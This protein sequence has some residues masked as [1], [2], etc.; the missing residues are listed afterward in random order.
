MNLHADYTTSYG[1][2]KIEKYI[3]IPMHSLGLLGNI[4]LWIVYSQGSLRKLSVSIYF[5]LVAIFCAFQCL[6]FLI[7]YIFD[8]SFS[9]IFKHSD[10]ACRLI[11]YSYFLPTPIA[12]WF[13]VAA[14][15]DRFL[16][17]VFPNKFTF[18]QRPIFQRI[19]VFAIIVYNMAF[20]FKNIFENNIENN[21]CVLD[22]NNPVIILDFINAGVCIFM[23][24]LI[25]TISTFYGVVQAH[26]R[27][28]LIINKDNLKRTRKRDI[29]F[30][31][32][33]I[34]LNVLFFI[35]NFP[36][37][38]NM[39]TFL[40]PFDQTAHPMAASVFITVLTYL[41]ELYFCVN[42]YIQLAVNNVVRKEFRNVLG[43]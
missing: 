33:M 23:L 36:Y 9:N 38:L 4:L 42:F 17:I 40:P 32:T 11:I 19:V 29:K 28:R 24:M 13:E 26:K 20:Y 2:L 8:E 34:V 22:L 41:F 7:Y 30:G 3:K 15:L 14:S 43:L 18:I 10:L 6:I 31:V 37:R 16:T 5:R 21:D 39:I 27:V 35:M 1:F 12:G 25:L